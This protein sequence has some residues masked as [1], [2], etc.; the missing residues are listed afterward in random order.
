MNQLPV[1]RATDGDARPN[2]WNERYWLSPLGRIQLDELTQDVLSTLSDAL[3][4][5]AVE[6]RNQ[7]ARFRRSR[8]RSRDGRGHGRGRTAP[9]RRTHE[10]HSSTEE[11]EGTV[12]LIRHA[13]LLEQNI[14]GL[15]L[16]HFKL[17]M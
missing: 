3:H 13:A 7:R 5:G 12:I 15:L 9:N 8:S 1:A 10:S 11:L 2:K 4:R 17:Y 14:Q 6:L 16:L